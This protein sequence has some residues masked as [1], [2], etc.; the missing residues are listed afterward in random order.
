LFAGGRDLDKPSQSYVYF[1]IGQDGTY[2][3]K[4]RDGD[5]TS[6]I[7]KGWVADPSIKK[8]DAKG[9]S[10]N[11]LEI[12][13]KRD[14]SKIV[15][16]INGKPVYTSDPKTLNLDGIVGL[17]VNHNLSVHIEGFDVHR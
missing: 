9:T 11:L 3:I 6:D 13:N 8:P 5:K 16:L 4:R 2:L 14:P 10:T 17:R 12:D 7:T 1:L 15:F